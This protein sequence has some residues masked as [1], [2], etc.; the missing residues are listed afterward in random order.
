MLPDQIPQTYDRFVS[1]RRRCALVV[2]V[3]TAGSLAGCGT[4]QLAAARVIGVV[5][6][7]GDPVRNATPAQAR[8]CTLQAGGVSILSAAGRVIA[9]G[10]LTR[11]RF[12]FALPPGRYTLTA[13]NQGNGP[14]KRRFTAIAGRD[15]Q[16]DVVIPTI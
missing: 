14:W 5:T 1:R 11:G 13:W 9:H 15:T 2:A 16:V 3:V 8:H 7:C 6:V 10:Q 12:S 4:S